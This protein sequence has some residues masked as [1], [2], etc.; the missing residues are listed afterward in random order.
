VSWGL[1][2]VRATSPVSM[3]W[4]GTC[5]GLRG[6]AGVGRRPR[7]HERHGERLNVQVPSRATACVGMTPQR[8]HAEVPQVSGCEGHVKTFDFDRAWLRRAHLAGLVGPGLSPRKGHRQAGSGAWVSVSAGKNGHQPFD[9]V[10]E[11]SILFGVDECDTRGKRTEAEHDGRVQGVGHD[12]DHHRAEGERHDEGNAEG[13]PRAER[14]AA[15]GAG[16]AERKAPPRPRPTELS[17]QQQQRQQQR[18][19]EEADTTG[20]TEAVSVTVSVSVS[21]HVADAIGRHEVSWVLAQGPLEALALVPSLVLSLVLRATLALIRWVL[22]GSLAPRRN[23]RRKSRHARRPAPFAVAAMACVRFTG[24][25]V[26]L[27]VLVATLI[28]A[29]LLAPIFLPSLRRLPVRTLGITL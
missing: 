29:W 15:A 21:G 17:W 10:P 12:D 20:V 4:S 14:A 7:S 23:S 28:A 19:R 8:A 25:C 22:V 13:M 18:M 3:T 16:A 2:T 24:V 1:E 11:P 5:H 27:A 9:G 26:R 6:M